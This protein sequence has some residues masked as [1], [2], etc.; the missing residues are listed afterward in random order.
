MT[1]LTEGTVAAIFADISCLI[2]VDIEIQEEGIAP[3]SAFRNLFIGILPAPISHA[4][5]CTLSTNTRHW[6]CRV[7][8]KLHR[9]FESLPLR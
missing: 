3:K 4:P 7:R 9:G 5:V 6:K 1:A 2:A 8:V